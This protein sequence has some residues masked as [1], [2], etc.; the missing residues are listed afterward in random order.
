MACP[1]TSSDAYLSC[2]GVQPRF[3]EEQVSTYADRAG[4]SG[5]DWIRPMTIAFLRVNRVIYW[6]NSP[7]GLVGD[8][9]GATNTNS[10]TIVA[11]KVSSQIPILG[12]LISGILGIF[13]GAHAQ[14]VIN[15]QATLCNV[16]VQYDQFADA[17][18]QAL[19]QGKIPLQD[20]LTQLKSVTDSLEQGLA[21]IEKKYNAPYGYNRAV[22][23]L[24][25]F[26]KEVVYPSLVPGAVGSALNTLTSPS[27]L[28]IAGGGLL[29]AK[30]LGVL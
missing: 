27:G 30:V 5:A 11:A 25:L 22:N 8:C 7:S 26:N 3:T 24:A 10:G 19:A 2:V 13:G 1:P 9:G 14:A 21:S 6:K 16:A 12:G 18:E 29:G 4:A 17:M 20:A 28:L 15:E 23:A